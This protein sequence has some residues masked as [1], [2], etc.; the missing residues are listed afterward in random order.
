MNKVTSIV[1]SGKLTVLDVG[2]GTDNV[3]KVF[4]P[5]GTIVTLDIDPEVNPDFVHDIRAPLPDD[6]YHK[7]DI[8]FCS[9]IL[10]HISFRETRATLKHLAKALKPG[11]EMWLITPSLEWVAE[12]I[13]KEGPIPPIIGC[14][15]GQ[16]NNPHQYHKSGWTLPMLRQAL[17]NANLI[18][19]Q[20]HHGS[21]QIGFHDDKSPDDIVYFKAVQNIVMG[22]SAPS[23]EQMA[24]TEFAAGFQKV[25][26]EAG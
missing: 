8:V 11:G 3:A 14:L 22:M 20:A 6:L 9:H 18:P 17:V 7:F 5:E 21:F 16:Q 13:R 2:A 25:Q 10:E 12:E 19:R 23:K 26:V 15:Y 4:F 1:R 24:D